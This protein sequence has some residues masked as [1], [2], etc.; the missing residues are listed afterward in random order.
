MAELVS[1]SAPQADERPEGETF[2]QISLLF[3]QIFSFLFKNNNG[4]ARCVC[5]KTSGV[6]EE[7]VWG[8]GCGGRVVDLPH[9]G[10]HL[11]PHHPPLAHMLCTTCIAHH[12]GVRHRPRRSHVCPMPPSTLVGCCRTPPRTH[13]HTHHHR[14]ACLTAPP[15]TNGIIHVP[16]VKTTRAERRA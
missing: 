10:Q 9:H 7:C 8:G 13:T 14:S 11:L 1:I 16:T 5:R 12:R 6:S 3:F 15:Q 2:F 4:P